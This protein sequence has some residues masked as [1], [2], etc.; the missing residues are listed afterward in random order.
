MSDLDDRIAFLT[1]RSYGISVKPPR[2]FAL[3][4]P[5]QQIHD[6]LRAHAAYYGTWPAS[7]EMSAAD[8]RV[9]LEETDRLR[10]QLFPSMSPPAG[11]DLLIMGALIVT[12]PEAARA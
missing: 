10:S 1:E 7:V 11:D 5:T 6:Y 3:R 4:S 8:K 2:V 12:T 9:F